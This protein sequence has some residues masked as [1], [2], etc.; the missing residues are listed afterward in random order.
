MRQP[1]TWPMLVIIICMVVPIW[2]LTNVLD[3]RYEQGPP[4][5][6][7]PPAQISFE[8][9]KE[10]HYVVVFRSNLDHDVYIDAVIFEND[11]KWSNS[12]LIGE[13]ALWFHTKEDRKPGVRTQH[14][15]P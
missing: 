9:I 8:E 13:A 4:P 2:I 6:Q 3:K 7:P 1:P 15:R 10:N 14:P 11:G 5:I 12:E